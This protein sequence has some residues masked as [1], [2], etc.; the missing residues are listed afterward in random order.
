MMKNRFI[1]DNKKKKLQDYKMTSQQVG[2][3]AEI[4][5]MAEVGRSW[6][7]GGRWQDGNLEDY[8][9]HANNQERNNQ[10]IE[11]EYQDRV[12]T[13]QPKSRRAN[14]RSAQAE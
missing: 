9:R 6:Q 1:Q 2:K 10:D 12:N 7:D 3:M 4:G 11:Q 13:S 14:R 5:K 8:H